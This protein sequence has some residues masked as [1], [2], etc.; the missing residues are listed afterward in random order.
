MFQSLFSFRRYWAFNF[1]LL[2]SN[3]ILSQHTLQREGE[4]KNKCASSKKK[5]RGSCH[6]HL[7]EEKVRK[8]KKIRS[9]KFENKGSGVVY[10]WG[11]Y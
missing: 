2:M 3:K 8:T 7:F 6:Q 4:A 11:R 1:N 5:T 9:T 10:A